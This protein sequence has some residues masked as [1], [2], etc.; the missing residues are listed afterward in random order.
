MFQSRRFCDSYRLGGGGCA[1][2]VDAPSSDRPPPT[3][4]DDGPSPPL[5]SDGPAPDDE[6]INQSCLFK[7]LDNLV[8]SILELDLFR[9]HTKSNSSLFFLFGGLLFESFFFFRE[10]EGVLRETE[11]ELIGREKE[12]NVYKG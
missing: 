4:A 11:R 7:S 2:A 10:M 12:G 3:V 1:A 5:G 9:A 6:S 8:F